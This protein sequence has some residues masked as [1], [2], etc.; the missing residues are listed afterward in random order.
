MNCASGE[1]PRVTISTNDLEVSYKNQVALNLGNQTISGNIHALVGHNGA[2]KSTLLKTILGLIIPSKG[3]ISMEYCDTIEKHQILIPEKHIA[4]C[5]ENGSVCSDIPVQQ[6]I[7][8]WCRLKQNDPNHYQTE[9]N[10]RILD[11]LDVKNLMKK[12]GRELSKGQ[13]RAVQTAIGFLTSP[14]LFLID[15]P[16]DGLDVQRTNL[17]AK[18]IKENN[19]K[20]TFIISSHRMDVMER[21]ADSVIVLNQGSLITNGSAEQVA[22][23]L[24]GATYIIE[25]NQHHNNIHKELVSRWPDSVVNSFGDYMT[26]TGSGIEQANIN[27]AIQGLSG[28]IKKVSP[29]LVD[30]MT[31]HLKSPMKFR[32]H[33]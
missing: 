3:S 31:F 23:S 8:L 1:I 32:K 25:T 11:H 10:Q 33:L 24:S 20:M 6:Y 26:I 4:Y 9:A 17:L 27:E 13:R 19:D 5:P 16:F 18:L 14:K 29:T 7:E 15:E 21:L 22:Q 28:N 12:L 2:G 30:A